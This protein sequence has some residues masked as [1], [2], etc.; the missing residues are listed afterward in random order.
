MRSKT[1]LSNLQEVHESGGDTSKGL[2]QYYTPPE[3][4]QQ[5]AEKLRVYRKGEYPDEVI[6]PQAGGKAL[7]DAF[8]AWTMRYAVDIKPPSGVNTNHRYII[9]DCRKFGEVVRDVAPDAIWDCGVANYPFGLRWKGDPPWK[10][11]WDFLRTRTRY[12]CMIG[13]EREIGHLANH[14]M[15]WDSETIPWHD[16]N[17][18]VRLIYYDTGITRE[19]PSFYWREIENV[20]EEEKRKLPEFNVWLK[21]SSVAGRVGSL[22]VFLSIRDQKKFDITHADAKRLMSLDGSTPQVLAVDK[23]TRKLLNSLVEAG[24]YKV[25]PEAEEAIRNAVSE[26]VRVS[27]PIMPVTDFERVA[28]LDEEDTV[29]CINDWG[30]FKRG[31]KYPV[32]SRN[33]SFKQHFTRRK[34][35]F[36]E[37]T[38]VM[39]TVDHECTLS[40]QD[41]KIVVGNHEFLANPSQDIENQHDEALLWQ[42]F[43]RPAVLTVADKFADKMHDNRQA[44]ETMEML[45]NIQFF[46]GQMDYLSRVLVRDNALIAAETGTGKTVMAIASYVVKGADRC[47]VVCPKGVAHSGGD[48]LSQ[49][50]A[51][52]HQFA[53]FVEVFKIFTHDDYLRIKRLNNGKLPAGFYVTYYDAFFKN[54]GIETC[55]TYGNGEPR[56]TDRKIADIIYPDHDWSDAQ[57]EEL[58]GHRLVE[59]VGMEHNGIRCIAKPSLSTLIGHEFDMV[60]L[61]EAHNIKGLN[62]N[63]TQA[64]IRLSPKYRFA[65]T[66][67]PVPNTATDIFTLMGWLCVDNWYRGGLSNAAFPFRREDLSRFNQLFLARERDHTAEAML[68]AGGKKKRR[69]EKVSPVLSSPAR[70]LKILKPAIAFITKT[71]CNADYLP[72]RIVDVRVP[73]GTQQSRLYAHFTDMNNIDR[74]IAGTAVRNGLVRHGAQIEWLR[75]IATDP[76]HAYLQS[77]RFNPATPAATSFNPKVMAIMELVNQ[78]VSNGEQVVIVN[79]RKGITDTIHRLCDEAGLSVSRIDSSDRSGNHSEESNLFKRGHTQVMLMGIKCAVGHSYSQCRNLIIGSLEYSPGPFEQARGRVDRLTS[80]ESRI[81]CILCRNT[82]EEVM[83]DT[84]AIKDDASK[85]ILRGQRVPRDFVPVDM[86]E[87]LMDSIMQWDDNQETIDEAVCREQ[88]ETLLSEI[89]A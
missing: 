55:S 35:H 50:V 38:G 80:K 42:I 22:G 43:S 13:S 16:A 87:V 54:G 8:P 31:E 57:A 85:I 10:W 27:T 23:E 33:Y 17:V 69:V 1:D 72:P 78:C 26:A 36:N 29:T 7:L 84:V 49:W 19:G 65:F 46:P 70:L 4:A 62:A 45:S 63:V 67:T 20:I 81:Y 34:P 61:D 24:I 48:E 74:T 47:L 77:K 18:E 3:L 59:T 88:W 6:D 71:Q 5:I 89:R 11:T 75:A 73:L 64:A 86:S 56:W 28:Y 32:R 58:S 52:I 14:P 82:I 79:A 60:C 21:E 44:L 9:A 41:R 83:F 76:A 40:G 66:A 2:A 12:G 68:E 30:P 15:V 51:E 53:P 25:Q 39:E 37:K